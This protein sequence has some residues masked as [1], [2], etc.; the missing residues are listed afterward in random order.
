M[1]AQHLEYGL[2]VQV[3]F[4]RWPRV[5]IYTFSY[6]GKTVKEVHGADPAV[7]YAEGLLDGFVR[8]FEYGKHFD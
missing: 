7:T 2:T 5:A 6:N 4:P 1:L 8:G 3:Y